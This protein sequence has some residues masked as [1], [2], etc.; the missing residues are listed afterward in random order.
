M[1]EPSPRAPSQSWFFCAVL[2]PKPN[3]M[4]TDEAGG[5]PQPPVRPDAGGFEQAAHRRV[6][7]AADAQYHQA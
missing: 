5:V 1:T 2:P 4:V 6:S 7:F 3:P